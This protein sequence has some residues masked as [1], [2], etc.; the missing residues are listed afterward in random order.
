MIPP[1]ATSHPREGQKLKEYSTLEEDRMDDSMVSEQMCCPNC[2]NVVHE[3]Y[4]EYDHCG[5]YC[6][7]KGVNITCWGCRESQP[8]QLAHIDYGGC[9]YQKKKKN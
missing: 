2:K 3:P 1:M 5:S 6:A 9:L 4:D 8:N 7:N